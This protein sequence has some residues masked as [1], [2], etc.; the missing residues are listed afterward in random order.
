MMRMLKH[1][2]G[3]YVAI[4]ENDEENDIARR[5]GAAFEGFANPERRPPVYLEPYE[6]YLA[7]NSEETPNETEPAPEPKH[8][9]AAIYLP[10]PLTTEERRVFDAWA[11]AFNTFMEKLN[12]NMA[13]N[14]TSQV[15]DHCTSSNKHDEDRSLSPDAL[16]N[17]KLP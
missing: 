3:W 5:W 7:Y 15:T 9:R 14:D 4:P 12:Q 17:E 13:A 1:S 16:L 10:H 2:G 6:Q 8:Q 11:A